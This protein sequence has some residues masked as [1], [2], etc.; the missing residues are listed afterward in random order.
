MPYCAGT[1]YFDILRLS[2]MHNL[3]PITRLISELVS[4]G[5]V[6]MLVFNKMEFEKC[7][8]IL[9]FR[10]SG[11]TLN[12]LHACLKNVHPTKLFSLTFPSGIT[13]SHQSVSFF[14]FHM[15]ELSVN[16]IQSITALW[17]RLPPWFLHCF[18]LLQ[19]ETC[20]F[21]STITAI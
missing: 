1:I 13:A 14:T 20:L 21:L 8:I 12:F 18:M 5:K 19:P 6:T 16:W 3:C 7:T 4:V 15:T 2:M 17:T 9:G 10:R 11:H